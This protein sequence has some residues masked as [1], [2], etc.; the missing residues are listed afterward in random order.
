MTNLELNIKVQKIKSL[1]C[2]LSDSRI[3]EIVL[4]KEAKLAKSLKRSS[5]RF[6]KREA[7][8]KFTIKNPSSF[9]TQNYLDEQRAIVMKRFNQ[10]N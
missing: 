10:N 6:E 3:E 7:A 5:K 9:D 4:A 2:K 8:E 1:G